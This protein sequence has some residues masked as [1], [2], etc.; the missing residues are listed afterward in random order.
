[1]HSQ[2]NKFHIFLNYISI[3]MHFPNSEKTWIKYNY[4]EKLLKHDMQLRQTVDLGMES[5]PKF[6]SPDLEL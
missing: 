6:I 5:T 3:T 1:M 2:Q 4:T